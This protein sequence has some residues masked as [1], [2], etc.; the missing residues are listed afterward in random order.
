MGG[1]SGDL[2]NGVFPI[3]FWANLYKWMEEMQSE[4]QQSEAILGE[5]GFQ[6]F[7]FLSELLKVECV[8]RCSSTCLHCS[9]ER[10]IGKTRLIML[11]KTFQEGSGEKRHFLSIPPGLTHNVNYFP[12][13][14]SS[15]FPSFDPICFLPL[16]STKRFTWK[17][18]VS[19]MHLF[20]RL[21]LLKH[22]DL[23]EAM[24]M[25]WIGEFHPEQRCWRMAWNGL[26]GE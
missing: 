14:L 13:L 26:W 25:E 24:K 22:R 6:E 10:Q 11:E 5:V 12:P 21:S 20:E 8:T 16:L 17:T 3:S 4:L 7:S 18:S 1:V 19:S 9:A 23:A 15:V 2:P